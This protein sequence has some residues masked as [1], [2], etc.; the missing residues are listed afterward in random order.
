M[1]KYEPIDWFQD[2]DFLDT[3]F[4]CYICVIFAINSLDFL[5]TQ[6]LLHMLPYIWYLPLVYFFGKDQTFI[7]SIHELGNLLGF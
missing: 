3:T 6:T 2:K 5:H 7:W 4:V 1:E